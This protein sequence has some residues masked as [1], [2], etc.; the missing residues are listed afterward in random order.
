MHCV[1]YK[2]LQEAEQLKTVAP[3]LSTLQTAQFACRFIYEHTSIIISIIPSA[4]FTSENNAML[5]QSRM[6]LTNQV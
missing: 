6:T 1:P 2:S 5:L 3:P 4:H